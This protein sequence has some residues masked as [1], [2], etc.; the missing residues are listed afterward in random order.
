MNMVTETKRLDYCDKLVDFYKSI[1]W[2][3]LFDFVR[4]KYG[5][6]MVQHPEA[7]MSKDG[8][9]EVSW[10]ENLKDKCGL[11]GKAYRE[12]RLRTFSSLNFHDVT[13]DKDILDEYKK[14][15]DFYKLDLSYADLNGTYSDAYLQIDISFYYKTYSGGYNYTDLFFAEYHNDTGWFICTAEGEKF[16]QE[17]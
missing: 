5:V 2:G 17:K 12:V 11:L 13:Y 1:D 4:K 15:P 9:I 7:K 3:W 10:P 6:G 16:Q 14:R 8:R